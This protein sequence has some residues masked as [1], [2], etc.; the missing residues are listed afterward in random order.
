MF[1]A[2]RLV[3]TLTVA[4]K[5]MPAQEKQILV[6]AASSLFDHFGNVLGV[7]QSDPDVFF[8]RDR[9][10]EAGKRGLDVNEIEALIA[11]RQ[12]AREDKDWLRA[13]DIRKELTLRKVLLK[14]S[15]GR[16]TWLVE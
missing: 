16:T 13:D 8:D 10:I 3:N 4:E 14:D 12:K 2:A 7:F 9:E 1:E 6:T 11:E 5:K 15:A